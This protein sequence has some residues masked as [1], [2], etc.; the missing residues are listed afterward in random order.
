LGPRLRQRR[1]GMYDGP[2]CILCTD[3]PNV[4]TVAGHVGRD[5]SGWQSF[6][7]YLFPSLS[8][9]AFPDKPKKHRGREQY[10]SLQLLRLTCQD[11]YA[12]I[13]HSR[14]ALEAATDRQRDEV[15]CVVIYYN[16]KRLSDTRLPDIRRF[17]PYTKHRINTDHITATGKSQP[18]RI[19]ED[20]PLHS[21]FTHPSRALEA[22]SLLG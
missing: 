4:S 16:I 10:R 12:P 11:R 20:R 9:V 6:S 2:L 5:I 22:Q 17:E 19:S 8:S 18:G 1:S 21:M 13:T 7:L 15:S 14:S 3:L